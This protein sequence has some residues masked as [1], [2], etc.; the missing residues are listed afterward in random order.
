M[1]LNQ[2]FVGHVD[3]PSPAGHV[4]RFVSSSVD[5]PKSTKRHQDPTL[6]A[7]GRPNRVVGMVVIHLVLEYGAVCWVTRLVIEL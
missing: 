6:R 7:V 4:H 5:I 3:F 2:K 1:H